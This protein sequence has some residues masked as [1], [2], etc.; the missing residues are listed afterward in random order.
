MFALLMRIASSTAITLIM[1]FSDKKT[2][3]NMA[4]FMANYA[5]CSC[6]SYYYM[7]GAGTQVFQNAE[8]IGFTIG[9]GLISGIWYLAAFL[10][11]QWN[12]R[13]NGV[14]LSSTFNRLGVLVPTIMAMTVFKESPK[15]IQIIGIVIALVA[16]V[17]MQFEKG[18]DQGGNKKIWLVVMLLSSGFCDSL[19]NVYDKLGNP[20]LKDN[21]L[22]YTFFVALI[23]AVILTIRERNKIS[24]WDLIFG[25]IIGVPNYYSSRFMFEALKTVPAMIAY[26]V[27]SVG[28]ILAISVG[29]VV[30]FKEKVSNQKK[31]ALVLVM[32]A[33]A[34]LN[35]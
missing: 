21:Y 1:R 11:M 30:L 6:L 19:T 26:P 32:A 20:I 8:G 9:I 22:L 31:F 27:S 34:L 17:L 29:S 28:T 25:F 23:S 10:F 24:K 14:V 35:M 13:E 4:M 18:G 16:I 7:T 2:S 33:M 12:M 5:V 3:N 15:M